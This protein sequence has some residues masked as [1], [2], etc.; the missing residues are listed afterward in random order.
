MIATSDSAILMKR[1]SECELK[2]AR[3]ESLFAQQRAK[4][5]DIGFSGDRAMA[6]Q[7]LAS[8]EQGLMRLHA[9][10]KQLTR[11]LVQISD[12]AAAGE[13]SKAKLE[14]SHVR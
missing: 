8:L 9:E 10:R 6:T 7:L 4:F 12:G 1:I 11:E 14:P 3:A 13:S 5:Y 2:L